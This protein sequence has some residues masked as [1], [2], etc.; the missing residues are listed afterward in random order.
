MTMGPRQAGPGFDGAPL[1]GCLS[2]KSIL[3]LAVGGLFAGAGLS[4]IVIGIVLR[5]Y[6]SVNEAGPY[7]MDAFAY[8]AFLFVCGS[9]GAAF[10]AAI[11]AALGATIGAALGK[12]RA[13]TA[14]GAAC[15]VLLAVAIPW[16]I[17]YT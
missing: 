12:K 11:G 7:D 17:T 16:A 3:G 2:L 1:K 15:G 8:L 10:G 4:A 13:G 9:V 14:F 5:S 6:Y